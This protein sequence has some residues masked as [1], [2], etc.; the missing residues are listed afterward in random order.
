[1][2]S[3]ACLAQSTDR[4]PPTAA[5]AA[6]CEVARDLVL[7]GR[8]AEAEKLLA[9]QAP[10]RLNR[11]CPACDMRVGK[12]C[13]DPGEPVVIDLGMTVIRERT[14]ITLVVPHAARL[15]ISSRDAGPLFR[16]AGR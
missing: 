12:P 8:I 15:G 7:L 6:V 1:M 2:L 16:E 3:H 4:R 14:W 10:R 11:K 13:R 5:D 9:E